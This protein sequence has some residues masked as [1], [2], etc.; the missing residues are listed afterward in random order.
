MPDKLKVIAVLGGRVCDERTYQKAY[1]VGRSI[2]EHGAVL[3]CGGRTGVMEAACK[4]ASEAGGLTIGILPGEDKDDANAW[5]QVVLPSG[6]GV[7]R[8]A[9]ITR[10]CDA[11]IAIGGK[12]GTLSEI[13]YCIQMN[14]PVCGLNSWPEIAGFRQFNTPQEA[15]AFTFGEQ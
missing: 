1:A 15:V 10:A 6:I 2:A 14:K 5:V 11:A 12:Y 9:I 3:L 4:G 13:A 8:N 7:A